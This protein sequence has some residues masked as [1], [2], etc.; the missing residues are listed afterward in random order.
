MKYL[1]FLITAFV[2]CQSTDSNKE[3]IVDSI[4]KAPADT[5]AFGKATVDTTTLN[6]N[7]FLIP[8]M[9][10]DTAAGR[11]AQLDFTISYKKFTG[12]TGC[13][14]MSG[15]FDVT[16]STLKFN[17]RIMLTKMAC[18][19]YNEH[20]FIESLLRT[21]SY[22]FDKGVLILLFNETEL[23]RWSRTRQETPKT[24]KI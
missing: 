9:A 17:E 22:R 13:N 5:S 14:S 16:D 2:A 6:G 21:N 18:P 24:N 23:S 20:E 7:W 8:V 4:E 1:L 12:N 19:G 10:S 11:L 15:N 3:S